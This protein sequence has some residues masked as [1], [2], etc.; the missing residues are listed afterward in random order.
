[1]NKK[2][3]LLFSTLIALF[4]F[5]IGFINLGN[6]EVIPTFSFDDSETEIESNYALYSE[7]SLPSGT[8]KAEGEN[9]STD[10][11]INF[12]SGKAYKTDKIVLSET[13]T[14]TVEYKTVY[15]DKIYKTEYDFIVLRTL[16][17]VSSPRST[18]EYGS[19]SEL[20]IPYTE[21]RSPKGLCVSLASG[22]KLQ[23]TGL[24]D[25][26]DSSKL[27]KAIQLYLTPFK[28]KAADA[29][30]LYVKFTD[31]YD[32]SN[33]V[34]ASLWS[35]N[36]N[37]YAGSNCRAAYLTAC[38][39]SIGQ[40]YLG[41]YVTYQD[42]GN[43]WVNA[44][45]KNM[46]TSG[47]CHFM[48]FYGN[49]ANGPITWKSSVPSSSAKTEPGFMV[50]YGTDDCYEGCNQ[51][52]L[53]FDYAQKQLKSN[54]ASIFG[55]GSNGVNSQDNIEIVADF[56][57]PNYYSSL[58]NGFKT[59]ECYMTVWAED[60]QNT[61]FNFVIT[62]C[63]GDNLTLEEPGTY[64]SDT[65]APQ[66]TI[67]Y[68]KY[69]KDTLPQAKVGCG[70]PVFKAEAIDGNDGSLSYKTRVYYG[71]G[72]D[73]Q[74]QV[75][76]LNGYFIPDRVGEYTILYITHD[77][78]GNERLETVKVIASNNANELNLVCDTTNAKK[79]ALLG[80]IVYIPEAT[81]SG[82]VGDLSYKATA[83]N[84]NTVYDASNGRFRPLEAGTYTVTIQVSDFIGQTVEASYEIV[85]ENQNNPVFDKEPNLPKYLFAG[86]TYH[87]D[88]VTAGDALV[89]AYIKIDGVETELVDFTLDTSEI[90]EDKN[91]TI[92]YRATKDSKTSEL[93]Y[94][95]PLTYAKSGSKGTD[96][97]KYF[98]LENATAEANSSSLILKASSLNDAKAT[99]KNKLIAQDF[100]AVFSISQGNFSELSM[101]LTDS[102]NYKE[103]VKFTWQKDSSVN[104]LLINGSV[105]KVLTL[106]DFAGTNP[107]NFVYDNNNHS[108]YDNDTLLEQIITTTMY[109]EEFNGF[110]SGYV[111]LTF[112]I[113]GVTG[114]AEITISSIN[115]Q[116]T[117]TNTRD[118]IS[119][120]I[121]FMGAEYPVKVFKGSTITLREFCAIDG[122]APTVEVYLEVKD[123]NSN[124]VKT[125]DGIALDGFTP[126]EAYGNIILDE[127]GT[128]T[129][130]YTVQDE[131]SLRPLVITYTIEALNLSTVEIKL[132]GEIKDTATVNET[133]SLP[134]ATV[135][136]VGTGTVDYYIMII[137]TNG[138]MQRISKNSLT[139]YQFKMAGTYIVVYIGLDA[140]GNSD[141]LRFYVNVIE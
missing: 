114:D 40:G 53:W 108:F 137:D 26:N 99:W 8:F 136:T 52:A 138:Y 122:I 42:N 50:A 85:V 86:Y 60:Y 111:Y 75:S 56:D 81:F 15:N 65:V 35:Y 101:T 116:V 74:Y 135:S 121:K 34:I 64:Y 118:A 132:D 45:F 83:K 44:V 110:S 21:E 102:V 98:D 5:S 125:T 107:T 97:T 66:I 37:D 47:F 57:D 96:L 25:L 123:S 3:I 41:H 9:L 61:T 68:D 95:I 139:N 79:N 39:P 105:S 54:Q 51:Y 67:D 126:F 119:P 29:F 94:E 1:M 20:G 131:N 73:S 69:T 89:K 71:Y 13:G 18:V 55:E 31:A 128:Y 109:G 22:D 77:A 27:N 141:V 72:T 80:E 19:P 127:A 115:T 124:Y 104:F 92:I 4:F 130:T 133:V 117:K 113:K 48:S 32:P 36:M 2:K 17:E 14:Y 84:E 16:Y 59:G 28:D 93:A 129:L 120:E 43:G 11:I 100:N 33:Y 87:F 103:A 90:E 23:Y 88:Q 62:E 76:S 82:G 140:N 78:A 24:I 63:N 12:P 46:R 30:S 7:F 58:W 112:E 134:S 106:L 10:A 49:N 38:V 6:A 91:T 70:Y